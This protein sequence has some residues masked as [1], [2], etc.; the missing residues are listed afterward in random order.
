MITF[1]TIECSGWVLK[2][3]GE[4]QNFQHFMVPNS[5][6]LYVTLYYIVQWQHQPSG[7]PFKTHLNLLEMCKISLVKLQNPPPQL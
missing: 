1:N 7:T 4:F 2:T 3:S 5:S 6:H